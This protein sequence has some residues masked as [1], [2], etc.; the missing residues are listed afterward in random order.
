MRPID[1]PINPKGSIQI[2]ELAVIEE[3]TIFGNW[4]LFELTTERF[5]LINQTSFEEYES[6]VTTDLIVVDGRSSSTVTSDRISIF[7]SMRLLFGKHAIEQAMNQ[8]KP[9]IC[10]LLFQGDYQETEMEPFTPNFKFDT[11]LERLQITDH[12]VTFK[13][14][15]ELYVVPT[16]MGYAPAIS[17]EM[18]SGQLRHVLCGAK[19][20]KDPLERLRA[21]HSNIVGLVV[22]I[23]KLSAD[24]TSPYQITT[25]PVLPQ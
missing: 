24:K 19:S 1:E 2:T 25:S 14:V 8:S 20:I 23:R 9:L 5:K 10:A 17:V 3:F 21:E 16:S 13:I 18:N 4:V 7:Q 11:T 15:S 6:A 22:S 12:W